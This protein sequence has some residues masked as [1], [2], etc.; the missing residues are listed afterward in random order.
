MRRTSNMLEIKIKDKS[1]KPKP[2]KK[3]KLSK[4]LFNWLVLVLVAVILGYAVVSF[5]FQTVT[6][7]GPSMNS[8]L[9]DGELVIVNKLT[10]KFEDID[11]YDIVAYSLVEKDGY[12]DIKR[13]IG[14]PGEKISI[15]DGV[16]NINGQPL[17]NSVINEK[18]LVSGIAKKEISLGE[19]EYFLIGDNVNN[20]E[21]SR[22]TNIGS[23]S[24]VEILG[25]VCFVLTPKESRGKVR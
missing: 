4:G 16:I 15:K 18:I 1:V 25:K 5:A 19:D 11:R 10:Y 9:K 3:S 23:V 21:D 24:K 14:L 13:V 20:S 2:K 17:D 7:I 6:V 22:Y 12:F 8:T